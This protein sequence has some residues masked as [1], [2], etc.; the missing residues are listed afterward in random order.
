MLKIG[1]VVL[2]AA[3]CMLMLLW[4]FILMLKSART[5]ASTVNQLYHVL[6]DEE[7]QRKISR[8]DSPTSVD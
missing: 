3:A 4:F 6:S 8:M 7:I 1:L 2:L 5:E